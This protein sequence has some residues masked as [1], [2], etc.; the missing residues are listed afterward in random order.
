MSSLYALLVTLVAGI[1]FW[2]GA[3]VTKVVKDKNKLIE[4][5]IA[6]ALF[7]M[8][9]LLAFDFIPHLGHIY[10]NINV[11]KKV[12]NIIFY[13]IVGILILK[14]LDVCI[15]D[16]HH[17]HKEKNDNHNE[18]NSHLFHIG[19]VTSISLIIHNIIEG[20]SIY[21]VSLTDLKSGA[22][23]ALG[24]MLHNIPLGVGIFASMN[25]DNLKR[26][27]KLMIMFVLSLSTFLGAF[28][29]YFLG[30]E[31]GEY[32]E[33]TLMCITL[34]MV[35]YITVFELL[36]EFWQHRKSKFSWWGMAVG[37]V[38]IGLTLLI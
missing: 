36:N 31:M 6:M 16:H 25:L 27:N 22:L 15:P 4:F 2:I 26:A 35:I 34:G 3:L 37:I 33:G 20:L 17:D 23:M 28:V 19:L 5:S 11:S 32:L 9:G 21:S 38:I 24:V 7:V 13:V 29:V 30:G 8:I 12:L 18:H 10:E 14:T 1:S